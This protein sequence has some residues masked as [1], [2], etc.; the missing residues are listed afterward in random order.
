VLI[1]VLTVCCALFVAACGRSPQ[2][3]LEKGNQCFAAGK[4][5]DAE[6]NYRKAAQKDAG[7]GDAFYRLGLTELQ[8]KDLPQAYN[9][10][11]SAVQLLPG[12]AEVQVALADLVLG[13]YLGD[14]RRPV[15]Y[16]Q[17]LTTLSDQLLSQDPN[18]FDGLRIKGNLAWSD[19]R[20]KE[21]SDIFARANAGRPLDPSLAPA[22]TQV[23]FLD[24]RFEEGERLA[25]EFLQKHKGSRQIYDVLHAHY[26]SQ[27]R[28]AEAENILRTKVRNNPAEIDYALQLAAHYASMGQREQMAAT[29]RSLSDPAVFPDTY[30][31]VGDF[32]SAHQSW[33]EALDQY[34]QG[35]RANSKQKIVYLKRIADAWLAQGKGEEAAGVVHEILRQQP[36]DENAR[37][38]DASLLLKKGK[39]EESLGTFRDLVK[40]SPDKPLWRFSLG[41][42]LVAKG[43]LDGARGQFE[44]S[45]KKRPDFMPAR[46]ALADVHR[47][48]HNYRETLRY[49]NE[50]LAVN[51]NLLQAR[52]LQAAG[53]IGTQ[54][55]A[56]AHA[57]L[58]ALEKEYPQNREVQYQLAA[59]EL[60]EKK[61][62]SAAARLQL[63]YAEAKDDPR[64]LTILVDVY[65]DQGRLDRALALLTAEL[66]KSPDSAT[67]R[68]MLA[69]T[70]MHA[71]NYDLALEHYQVLQA[72]GIRSEQLQMRLGAVYEFK[73]KY[74]EAVAAFEMAKNLAPRDP[75]ASAALADALRLAG[76]KADA[77]AN[78]RGALA[79]DPENPKTMNSL[80]Y[81]LADDSDKLDEARS[82][83]E[84]ALQKAPGEPDFA[85]TLGLVYLRKNLA[86]SAAHVFENLVKKHP[87]NSLY[88]YHYGLA[89]FQTGQKAKAKAELEA[90][91]PKRPSEGVRRDIETA[92]AKIGQ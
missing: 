25:G 39:V 13:A 22:W 20:L 55:Y 29:L 37:A 60:A 44:E 14:K 42:A 90:A 26:L 81:L 34:E 62:P 68:A 23:L 12:R 72:R 50:V 43:D 27:N 65:R 51:A 35:V 91:L 83:A 70:A 17:Q 56:K 89:L 7:F 79:L 38:V 46:L 88:L 30:L 4:Y 2:G 48:K 16:Y 18:S 59:L 74:P 47:L 31:K 82:L 73:G 80:A 69:D 28:L 6:L 52:L 10:L 64:A 61:Y 3:Y 8:K 45:L 57:G 78:Y 21:A 85:D 58:A 19:G 24:G 49:A 76:R 53:L 9:A 77:V 63:L 32:Y 86:D 75:A 84:R 87:D 40:A 15:R 11:T 33:P 5:D 66:K 92:L 67:I 36:A 54:Q 41:R 1:R 71:R